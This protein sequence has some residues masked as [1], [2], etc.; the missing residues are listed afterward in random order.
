M[1]RRGAKIEAVHF[2]SFPYT[3]E[4]AKEKVL[5]LAG[6]VSEYAGSMKVHVLSLTRIQEQLK[7][8]C[9]E[10]YFTL[11]LRRSMMRHFLPHGSPAWLPV[12]HNRRELGAGGLSDHAG[13]VRHRRGL[14]PAGAAPLDRHG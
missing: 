2:E 7:R 12:P 9:C 4:R 5:T 13:P 3:S 14:R 6:L 8:Q 1:A 10:D 11:L